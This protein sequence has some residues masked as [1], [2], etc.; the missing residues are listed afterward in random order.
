MLI[1]CFVY[2]LRVYLLSRVGLHVGSLFFFILSVG[3]G[4]GL[5]LPGPSG[6]A[7][8]SSWR[9]DSFGLR[10][11]LESFDEKGTEE[12]S[13]NQ[14]PANP[15][16]SP[17]E[18]AS[19]PHVV[20]YPYQP[21]EV[22]G[23]DSVLSIQRRLLAKDPSP[24]AEVIQQARIQAEDLF[25]VKVE[26]F[27]VMSGLDPEGDWLGRGARA[28]ENSRTSTGEESLEKLYTLRED[29][30]RRGVNSEAFSLLK[31]RVPLRRDGDEHS[32]T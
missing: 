13:V 19:P 3:A 15:V 21:D 23:G 24:S 10:V 25:E 16:A 18:A 8:S 31:E 30:E 11:L 28:L 27:R 26:I 12:S 9:E 14:P 5:P 6:P 1:S 20:P 4:Q 32:T 2:F 22:I 7:S 17:E 29:L